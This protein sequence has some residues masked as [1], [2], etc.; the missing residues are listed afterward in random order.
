MSAQEAPSL[1]IAPI[2]SWLK[3]MGYLSHEPGRPRAVVVTALYLA[4]KQGDDVAVAP[5]SGLIAAGP[6]IVAFED[7][8]ENLLLRRSLAGYGALIALKGD[9]RRHG[10][11]RSDR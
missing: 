3:K 5:L 4:R 9:R 6:P 8:E 2:L 7:I 1:S 11:G 10:Q